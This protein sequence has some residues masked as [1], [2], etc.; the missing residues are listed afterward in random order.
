MT[1]QAL[2][3]ECAKLGL[4]LG[5]VTITKL[6]GGK[7]EAV[8]IA[9]MIVLARA[10][11]VAPADLLI[12]PGT[13]GTVEMLPGDFWPAADAARWLATGTDA[14]TIGTLRCKVAELSGLL[15]AALP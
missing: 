13:P 2:A 6:E 12:R 3:D 15:G 14:A 4:P 5:R 11:S 10:L 8:S 1:V 9:E 7:R